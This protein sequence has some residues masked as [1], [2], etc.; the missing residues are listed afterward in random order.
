[1]R[2]NK[3]TTRQFVRAAGATMKAFYCTQKAKE[4]KADFPRQLAELQEELKKEE[5]AKYPDPAHIKRIKAAIAVKQAQ[6]DRYC[7]TDR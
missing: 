7:G 3:S 1:M 4:T 2:E 6:V 5:S